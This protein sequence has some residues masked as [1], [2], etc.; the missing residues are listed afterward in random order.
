MK[1]RF[2]AHNLISAGQAAVFIRLSL[3]IGSV[4][5]EVLENILFVPDF[6]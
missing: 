5:Y 6:P 4:P 2:T 1:L 3:F